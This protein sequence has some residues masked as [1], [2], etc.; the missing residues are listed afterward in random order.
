M[1]VLDFQKRLKS[2][3]PGVQSRVSE[4]GQHEQFSEMIAVESF[5]GDHSLHLRF[6]L[7]NP[8]C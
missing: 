7:S 6:C 8:R 4:G 2:L 3:D 5:R 1:N